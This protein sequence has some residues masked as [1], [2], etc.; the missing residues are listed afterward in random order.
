MAAALIFR[1]GAPDFLHERSPEQLGD[2][3]ALGTPRARWCLETLAN[4]PGFA[5]PFRHKAARLASELAERGVESQAPPAPGEFSHGIVTMVDGMGSRTATLFLRTPTGGIDAFSVML[6]DEIGVKDATAFFENGD[7]LEKMLRCGPEPISMASASVSLFRELLADSFALHEELGTA[8]PGRLFPLI[9]YLG[10]ELVVPRKREPDLSAYGLEM[11][12]VT[13]ELFTDGILLA[14]NPLYGCLFPAS[15]EAYAFCEAHWDKRRKSIHASD[16][17]MF[18]Q[19]IMP[20]E[21]ERLLRRIAINLEVEALVGRAQDEDNQAAARLWLGAKENVV[22]FWTIPFVQELADLSIVHIADD[23]RRGFKNQ[24]EAFAASEEEPAS[25]YEELANLF[26][27]EALDSMSKPEREAVFTSMLKQLFGD[28][29]PGDFSPPVR[30]AKPQ[31]KAKAKKKTVQRGWVYVGPLE[32]KKSAPADGEKAG[33]AKKRNIYRLSVDVRGWPPPLDEFMQAHPG[34]VREIA[35]GGDQTLDKLHQA[36]FKAF[37]RDDMHAYEF[38]F[39]DKPMEPGVPRYTHP[40]LIDNDS[41]GGLVHNAAITT[42]DELGLEVGQTF[43]Y[44]FDFGDDWWH[45]ITVKE[46][47][48]PAP[49]SRYPK[50]VA[51][52]GFSP[53]QYPRM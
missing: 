25:S 28:A 50:V 23:L 14:E 32:T 37:E 13:P 2:I 7:E 36:I 20:L 46:I 42:L 48:P 52:H 1:V 45:G 11:L 47:S 39:S 31:R 21:Q 49:R 18:L 33:S 51:K 17:S 5:M 27:R 53:P 3:H 16:F 44:W 34:I 40:N 6:N 19:E 26:G 43:L 22:Q 9:A 30:D 8:P 41:E 15:D 35:V 38:Q 29:N 12:P 4:W 24:R 10:D